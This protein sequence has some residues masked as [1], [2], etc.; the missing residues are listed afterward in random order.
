MS[1]G[2]IV[3]SVA[4]LLKN[5]SDIALYSQM[6]EQ[7]QK[8]INRSG[9]DYDI[10]KNNN[11]RELFLELELLLLE[12]INNRFNDFLNL[13]YAVDVFEKEIR[14]CTSEESTVIAGYGA[15]LI[16]KREWQKVYYRNRL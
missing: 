16:L 12:V 3:V 13:L 4:K 2:A 9:I 8:D 11:P 7:L 1:K 15:Y 6:I 14:K 10:N 5:F